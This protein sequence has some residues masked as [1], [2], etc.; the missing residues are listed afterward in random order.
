MINAMVSR[1]QTQEIK[2][3]HEKIDK[4]P[5]VIIRR[6]DDRYYKKDIADNQFITRREAR[7]ANALITISITAL[8]VWATIVSFFKSS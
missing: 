2:D 1:I 8:G 5:D 3:L 6:L 4:L 7:V